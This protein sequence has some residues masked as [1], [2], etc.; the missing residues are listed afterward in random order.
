MSKNMGLPDNLSNVLY[1]YITDGQAY[2]DIDGS[3][4]QVFDILLGC[5]QGSI[6][7][8][9]IFS[10]F[11]R[12]LNKLKSYLTSYAYDSYGILEVGPEVD[13]APPEISERMDWLKQSGMLVNESKTELMI[14]HKNNRLKKALEI[15]NQRIETIL[16]MNVL[17]VTF[18]CNLNWSPH[19]IKSNNCCQNSFTVLKSFV[20]TFHKKN[21]FSVN[22]FML[23]KYSNITF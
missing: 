4:S 6:L 22:C 16:T 21:S 3:T 5:V 12:P 17:G 19:V 18:N 8:P 20:N 7:G 11:M 2:V 14:L 13:V 1:D 10:I 9:V 23:V 15:N